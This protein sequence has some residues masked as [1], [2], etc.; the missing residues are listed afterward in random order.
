M[1]VI[2]NQKEL[3]FSG[4]KEVKGVK[5]NTINYMIVEAFVCNS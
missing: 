5:D 3:K 4:V 1:K 2:C